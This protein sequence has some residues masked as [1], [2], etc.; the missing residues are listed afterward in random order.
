TSP[1]LYTV[2]LTVSNEDGT[3]EPEIKTDYILIGETP[4]IELSMTE[5]SSVGANDGTITVDVTGGEPPYTYAW[6]NGGDT[7]AITGLTAGTYCVTVIDTNGCSAEA[8]IEV[9]VNNED[10]FTANFE[11]DIIEGCAPLTVQF[12]DLSIGD[13][14][15]WTWNFGDGGTSSS[16]NPTFTFENPGTYNV[17]L[18]I[19]NEDNDSDTEVKNAYI[20]VYESP[21][22]TI[23]EIID[24]TGEDIADG[25]ATISI[26]NGTEPYTI[27]WSNDETGLTIENVLPGNYSVMVQDA[28]GCVV[29]SPVVIG[30]NVF[31]DIENSGSLTIYPNPA[32]SM[33]N[34]ITGDDNANSIIISDVLG[35]SIININNPRLNQEI[36]VS[37]LNAG[38]YFVKVDLNGKEIVKKLIVK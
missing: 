9:T 21:E 14:I 22:I 27:L 19:L 31:V 1:G 12:T 26:S 20:T 23:D 30:W 24:A 28:N 4:Q 13:P 8:C 3:S 5:E 6:D 2:S 18:I 10:P 35:K 11:A 37:E 33:I 38:I 7:H 29:S 34:V 36:D 16:Q 25:S 17:M 32:N 15:A